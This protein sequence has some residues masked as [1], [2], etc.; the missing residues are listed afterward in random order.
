V[1]KKLTVLILYQFQEHDNLLIRLKEKLK[2]KN[3]ELSL[4]NTRTFMFSEKLNKFWFLQ[5]LIKIPKIRVIVYLLF[6]NKI[7]LSLAKNYEIIDIHYFSTIYD[8]VLEKLNHMNVKISFWGSDAYRIS[9]ERKQNLNKITGYSKIIRFNTVEMYEKM[10]SFFEQKEKLGHQI[11]GNSF[12]DSIREIKISKTDAKRKLN[13]PTEKTSVFVGYNAS[14][15]QQHKLI[16]NKL[17]ELPSGIKSEIVLVLPLTYGGNQIWKEEI[18]ENA[19]NTGIEI[20]AFCEELTEKEVCLLRLSSDIVLNFQISDAFSGSLQ[21]HFYTNSIM[22]LGEWLPYKWLASKGLFFYAINENQ[23]IE[24]IS[25]II[26]NFEQEKQK[27]E[28]NKNIIYYIS[29]WETVTELWAN[30]YKQMIK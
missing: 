25:K 19:K 22:I 29:S 17:S 28:S 6:R 10:D 12:F 11:F 14:K 13:I 18:I 5:H 30:E 16:L 1:D 27:F 21:E 23:I 3:I 8:H 7:I 4:F 24:L 26:E 20:K 9:E 15:G 2:S